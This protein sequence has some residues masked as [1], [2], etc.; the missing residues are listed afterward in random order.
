MTKPQPHKDSEETLAW[1]AKKQAEDAAGEKVG[2]IIGS[3]ILYGGILYF[4]YLLWSQMPVTKNN[5][6]R[7]FG[8]E[9]GDWTT[10]PD[11]H[12]GIV[13]GRDGFPPKGSWTTSGNVRDGIV[14]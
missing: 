1:L 13:T 12:N 8:P 5:Y 3:I 11:V 9:R 10:H 6:D 2:A 4:A 7:P 14:Q